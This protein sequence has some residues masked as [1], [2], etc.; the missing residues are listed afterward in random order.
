MKGI[1]CCLG[2]LRQMQRHGRA[3]V[4][5]LKAHLVGWTREV[6]DQ[7]VHGTTAEV[8][9]Q[10][11]QRAERQALQPLP[12]QPSFLAERELVRIVHNDCF[13]EVEATWYSAPQALIRQRVSVLV[14]YQQVL[15]RHG[16]SIV[17]KHMH[18]RPVG[19][20]VM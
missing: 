19:A 2:G 8:P 9:L 12:N 17:D 1:E 7:R 14:R 11:F 3:K 10:R 18:H 13:V 15:I 4:Q 20:A 16:G 6:A 5:Q